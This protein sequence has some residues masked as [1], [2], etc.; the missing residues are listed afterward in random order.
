MLQPRMQAS[1][2][3]AQSEL[4]EL[5]KFE[6][7]APF[8]RYWIQGPHELQVTVPGSSFALGAEAAR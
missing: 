8:D 2:S 1:A 4:V 5:P 7:H 6:P 3:P